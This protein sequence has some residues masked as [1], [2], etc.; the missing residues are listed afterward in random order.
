MADSHHFLR[1]LSDSEW[2]PPD[3]PRWSGTVAR[4]LHAHPEI[5]SLTRAAFLPTARRGLECGLFWYGT[6]TGPKSA[7]TAIVVPDQINSWGHYELPEHAVDSLSEA[8]RSRGWFNL[9]QVHTHPSRWVGHSD[10]DNRYANSRSALSLVFPLYGKI[11]PRW[12]DEIGVHEF[13]EGRWQRLSD[14]RVPL[15]VVFDSTLPIPEVIDLRPRNV[16]YTNPRKSR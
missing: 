14:E 9:T 15:R 12:P 7:V 5:L 8:T 1:D 3:P 2:N 10:Y 13:L 4:V 16:I 6:S 11:L